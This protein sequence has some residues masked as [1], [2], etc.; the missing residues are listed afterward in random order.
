MPPEESIGETGR[1]FIRNLPYIATEED[2][3]KLFNK[4]GPLAEVIN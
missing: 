1:L 3:Q 2:L 4:Y